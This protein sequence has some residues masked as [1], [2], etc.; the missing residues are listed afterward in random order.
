MEKIKHEILVKFRDICG[1]LFRALPPGL[2]G[3]SYLGKHLNNLILRHCGI[4]VDSDFK[5]V[6]TMKDG[7]RLKFDLRNRQSIEPFY[8]GRSNLGLICNIEKMLERRDKPLM[9]DI[10]ANIG[11]VSIPIAYN[12]RSRNVAVHAFEPLEGN[13][14][15]L[16][17]NKELNALD[18]IVLHRYGLGDKTGDFRISFNRN[19]DTSNAMILKDESQ[20]KA[21]NHGHRAG[22][23]DIEKTSAITNDMVNRAID[24]EGYNDNQEVKIKKLDDVWKEEGL[25]RC[26]LI[27][28]DVE[29]FELQVLKGGINFIQ[30]YRPVIFGEFAACFIKYNK[31]SMKDVCN[32][33]R[34]LGYK[35]YF[36][37]GN[38]FTEIKGDPEYSSD[39]VFI[40]STERRDS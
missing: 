28:I 21:V 31:Y 16:R 38:G 36:A 7:Y 6:V 34:P 9:L 18:N 14:K 8:T 17:F 24:T 12:L 40:H 25:D 39:T 15:Y 22:F 32:L 1:R 5:R 13:F 26:S 30:T 29:G 19:A 2:K 10:G 35:L 27:K 37:D 11:L 23:K 20:A 33:L 4:S 3:R